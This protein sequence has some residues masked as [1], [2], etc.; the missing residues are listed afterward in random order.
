[1]PEVIGSTQHCVL[2]GLM[3][4]GKTTVGVALSSRLRW[5]FRD[6]DDNIL[7]S[8]GLTVRE[9]GERDGVAAMHALEVDTLLA[10]MAAPGPTIIG[11]AASVVDD[12]ACRRAL[13]DPLYL[14]V[15]L[16]AGPELLARRFASSDAHRPDFGGPPE[17]VLADQLLARG[18][19]LATVADVVIDV[20][21]LTPDDIAARVAE[22]LASIGP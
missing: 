21:I 16:R 19:S 1:M 6:S 3:G 13:A 5:T 2:V 22:A 17:A 4:A 18:P 8:T 7:A 9:L 12:E 10:A 20:D 14:V 11:A 15:W